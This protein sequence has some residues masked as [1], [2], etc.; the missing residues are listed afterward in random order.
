MYNEKRDHF[1][2]PLTVIKDQK[3]ESQF[4]SNADQLEQQLEITEKGKTQ[5][6]SVMFSFL[7][8]YLKKPQTQDRTEWLTQAFQKYTDLWKTDTEAREEAQTIVKTIDLY[9][10][11]RAELTEWKVSGKSRDSWMS[12]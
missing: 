6:A 7:R 12:R 4:E 1:S 9:E 2:D 3:L 8:S 10:K 11:K 5:T